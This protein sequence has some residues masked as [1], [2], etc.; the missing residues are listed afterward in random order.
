MCVYINLKESLQYTIHRIHVIVHV[1][2][3]TYVHMC[4]HIYIYLHMAFKFH[5]MQM[6][7]TLHMCKCGK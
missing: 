3:C 5:K 6:N 1:Y 4:M 2:V 7:M